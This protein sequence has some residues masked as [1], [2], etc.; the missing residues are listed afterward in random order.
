MARDCI[1]D[2]LQ[3]SRPLRNLDGP[4]PNPYAFMICRPSD[5]SLSS[6]WQS[7]K[8]QPCIPGQ[9]FPSPWRWVDPRSPRP[10]PMRLWDQRTRQGPSPRARPRL[11]PSGAVSTPSS[12]SRPRS[13]SP[14][15]WPSRWAP[16]RSR[17]NMGWR[18]SPCFSSSSGWPPI[19]TPA[20]GWSRPQDLGRFASSASVCLQAPRLSPS[21]NSSGLHG[22]TAASRGN[23]PP[24]PRP[25][26]FL[27]RVRDSIADRAA[28]PRPLACGF[29]ARWLYSARHAQG[30]PPCPEL[31]L[32]AA[33]C[34]PRRTASPATA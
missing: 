33:T 18:Q 29:G 27:A 5:I 30:D 1:L 15:T 25:R 4:R 14:S 10:P 19:G 16:G 20:P 13:L 31:T 32:D 34:G 8:E 3:A 11:V 6:R 21:P 23:L 9:P 26:P 7:R 12:P 17:G 28:G 22:Y 2:P 24:R